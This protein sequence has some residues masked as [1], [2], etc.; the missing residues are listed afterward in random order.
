M[1][2]HN[3]NYFP[4]FRNLNSIESTYFYELKKFEIEVTL[5]KPYF[6]VIRV[7]STYAFAEYSLPVILYLQIMLYC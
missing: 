2:I 4:S 5:L 6:I 7:L 3:K 1:L